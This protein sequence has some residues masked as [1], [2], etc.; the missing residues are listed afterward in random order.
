MSK[1]RIY[2]AGA[3]IGA[4]VLAGCGQ[5]PGENTSSTTEYGS[6]DITLVVPYKAGGATDAVA[7]IIADNLSEHIPNNPTVRVQNVAGGS[8]VVGM[9]K[10]KK[11]DPDGYTIALTTS[12]AIPLQLPYGKIDIALDDFS[13]I[14][15]LYAIGDVLAGVG[16]KSEWDSYD[17]FVSDAKSRPGKI[18]VATSGVGSTADLAVTG[19]E[20]K[21]GIKLN[22]VPY[23]GGGEALTA[24][25]GKHVDAV[26]SGNMID[27]IEDGTL[28]GLVMFGE[29]PKFD[30]VPTSEDVDLGFLLPKMA[31]IVGPADLP[32]DVVETLDAALKETLADDKVAE[33][34][35]D[36]G[37][38]PSY[39]ESDEYWEEV[40]QQLEIGK[41]LM[42]TADLID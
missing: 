38:P 23:N 42:K 22:R 5:G 30:D 8:G 20:E 15:Q 17:D 41:K 25:L 32:S 36:L 3:V 34:M 26:A 28:H 11:S 16:E 21:E 7:R 10:V 40:N 14:S 4:F 9:D 13:P 29:Q 37:M 35:T 18:S 2:A 31:G 39:L 24:A 27:E 19:L 33:K 12:T 6:K 1:T